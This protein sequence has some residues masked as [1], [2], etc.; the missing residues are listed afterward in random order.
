MPD[1]AEGPADS[2][3]QPWAGRQFQSNPSADD[4]G[5]APPE[6]IAAID[7]FRA[8]S[9]T[10]VDV[11]DAVRRARFLIPL[12]AQP[13]GSAATN[14][15]IAEDK[16]QEF[17]IVLVSAP[18][19]RRVLPVFSSVHAMARWNPA[20]RPFPASGPRVAL[21]A[22]SE[23]TDIV[24]ID[25]GSSTEFAIRRPA[26]WAIAKEH[27]WAPSFRDRLV[28]EEFLRLSAGD[29]TVI[30]LQLAPADPDARLTAPELLVQLTLRPGL[31]REAL[32][33]LL[34]RLQG[35]WATSEIIAERVD[36]LALKL[37]AD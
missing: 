19:G 13:A 35:R 28:L 6:L 17:S 25:P 11:V 8:G 26:L 14:S 23:Q 24:V 30:A 1:H 27:P 31:D 4:D 21:A 18:D 7:G 16:G 37:S 32:D 33:A 15:S 20:A 2:A 29:D 12:L 34:A 10:E 36:S 3:G 22:A 9:L 5:S